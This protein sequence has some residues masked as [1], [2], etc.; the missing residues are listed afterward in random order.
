MFTSNLTE[1]TL[2]LAAQIENKVAA[3]HKHA[4]ENA[5]LIN[6]GISGL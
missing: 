1:Q 4:D 5:F 3:F 2:T 6:K